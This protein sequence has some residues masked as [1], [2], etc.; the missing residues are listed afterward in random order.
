VRGPVVAVGLGQ[1]PVDGLALRPVRTHRRAEDPA[2]EL[3]GQASDVRAQLAEHLL[4]LLRQS[5][6]R[7]AS[8][9]ASSRIALASLRASASAA[10]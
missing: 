6:I 1:E 2:G 10:W 3:G 5:R 9:R 7:C 8:A 4:A